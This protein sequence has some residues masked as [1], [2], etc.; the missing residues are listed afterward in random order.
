MH[1]HDLS[2]IPSKV[3]NQLF[4]RVDLRLYIGFLLGFVLRKFGLQ[5][6]ELMLRVQVLGEES[7]KF[8]S[9]RYFSSLT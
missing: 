7:Q 9:N 8:L 1:R 5:G 3:S 2:Y 6:F 4:E